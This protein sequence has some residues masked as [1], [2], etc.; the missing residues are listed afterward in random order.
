MG[1]LFKHLPRDWRWHAAAKQI[2]RG[3][4]EG[5]DGFHC[6]RI[7]HTIYRPRI[8]TAIFHQ[9]LD[10]LYR[11][12]AVRNPQLSVQPKDQFAF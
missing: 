5:V 8:E 7:K 6:R 11:W 2:M 10:M 9:H 12:R 3:L 1:A 4:L